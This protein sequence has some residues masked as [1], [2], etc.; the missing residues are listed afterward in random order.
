MLFALLVLLGF[1]LKLAS[2]FPAT[3]LPEWPAWLCWAL[4]ALIWALPALR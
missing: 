1:I 2:C 4:S 3:R